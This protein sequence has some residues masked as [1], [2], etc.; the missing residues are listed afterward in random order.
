MNTFII[1]GSFL[2]TLI[3][4][5]ENIDLKETLYSQNREIDKLNNYLENYEIYKRNKANNERYRSLS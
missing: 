4:I 5:V 2:I 3:C 1:I